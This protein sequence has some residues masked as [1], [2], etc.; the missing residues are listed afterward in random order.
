[1]RL[2]RHLKHFPITPEVDIEPDEKGTYHILSIVAGDQPDLLS[3]IAQ[4]LARSNVRVHS[5]RINTMGAR[6]EDIFLITGSILNE[7]RTLIH[8]ETELLRILQTSDEKIQAKSEE[9]LH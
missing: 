9:Y 6:A 4:A 5:A 7:T 2:S 1:V 8:L 3:R